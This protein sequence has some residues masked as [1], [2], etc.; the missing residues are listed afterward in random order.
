[1][2][3][4]LIFLVVLLAV[5]LVVALLVR[6]RRH[7]DA[8]GRSTVAAVRHL[9]YYVLAF[10][11]LMV[12][13]AGATVLIEF[14]VD[15]LRG[16]FHVEPSVDQLALGIALS[17]VGLPAWWFF[18]ARIE[19]ALE[20]APG[21][22]IS[23]VRFGYVYAI[24]VISAAIAMPTTMMLLGSIFG[25]PGFVGQFV[26][27]PVV[28]GALWVFHW[29]V[30]QQCGQPTAFADLTRRLYLYAASLGSVVMLLVGVD[31]VLGRL[32]NVGYSAAFL[33]EA[34]RASLWT[35]SVQRGLAAGI[36]GVVFWAWHWRRASA[37]DAGSTI[38]QAY[39]YVFTILG[40]VLTFVAALS[41]VLDLLLR[42]A[43][44][45]PHLLPAA[46]HFRSVPALVAALLV[47]AGLWAYHR[48][49]LNRESRAVADA[50]AAAR[51]AYDHILAGVG[52]AA[53]AGGVVFVVALLI[54]LGVPEARSY[55]GGQGGWRSQLALVITLLLVGFSFWG[56]YWMRLQ[57]V[58]ARFPEERAAQS[59][60]IFIYSVFGLAALTAL[61][62]LSATLYM[63]LRAAL[64]GEWNAHVLTD[65]KWAL[66]VLLA[67]A[68]ICVYYWTVLRED[69]RT[70]ERVAPA[71]RAA[72]SRKQVIVVASAGAE[73]AVQQLETR[74][75]YG[76]TWWR[77][78][79][80]E[81]VPAGLSEAIAE[82]AR[83]VEEAAAPQ[84]LALIDTR[85]IRVVAYVRESRPGRR[86]TRSSI[87]PSSPGG[88]S[89]TPGVAHG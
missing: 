19:R 78:A 26:A 63:L 39:L 54:A 58:A 62:G 29:R 66:G 79:S 82:A 23:P 75:G 48:R 35:S 76:V 9:Y 73:E 64:E 59:R 37:E 18:W 50:H 14:I 28:W 22:A 41:I 43:L 1:M 3:S 57:R 81:G 34:P 83:D 44:R 86:P 10:A 60:R 53:L 80:D 61:G 84:V 21:D 52:L 32:L 8:Q 42:W 2:V 46:Q 85:G 12:G 11:A 72:P 49:V 87:T 6:S 31:L 7:P 13:A 74:L 45:A 77:N 40:G 70:L 55:V 20:D 24:L 16:G 38:R 56:W 89:P 15:R 69:R 65:L 33:S 36:A 88:E 25:A 67:A 51:R 17:A 71:G 47:G 30:A 68:A 4:S 5:V 27:M